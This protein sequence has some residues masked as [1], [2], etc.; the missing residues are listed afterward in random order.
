MRTPT[1][2]LLTLLLVSCSYSLIYAQVGIGIRGGIFSSKDAFEDDGSTATVIDDENVNGYIVSVPIEFAL[3]NVFAIQPEINLQKRGTD[4]IAQ[5]ELDNF[6]EVRQRLRREFTYLEIPLLFKLGYTSDRFTIA[7]VAGP[8]VSYALNGKANAEAF[9]NLEGVELQAGQGEYDIDFDEEGIKRVDVGAH[10]GAQL[11][12]PFGPGKFII[13]GRY[14]LGFVNL[15]D[16]NDGN[17]VNPED[18][19][20]RGRGYTATLGYMFTLGNY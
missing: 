14:Q 20:T 4:R 19:E 2:L 5:F 16:G 12:F 17:N 6:N 3:S 15:N 11:G 10:L 9:T 18:Y 1:K 13:D 8:S 7:A